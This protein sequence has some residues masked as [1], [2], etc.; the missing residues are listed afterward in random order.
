MDNTVSSDQVFTLQADVTP[1]ATTVNNTATI[2][3][4]SGLSSIDPV[5][6]AF[7]DGDGTPEV[8]PV[9]H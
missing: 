9:P 8:D 7:A 6:Q 4:S 3:L 1:E 5:T 2:V